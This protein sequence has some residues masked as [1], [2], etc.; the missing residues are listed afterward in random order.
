VEE[1]GPEIDRNIPLRSREGTLTWH[2]LVDGRALMGSAEELQR[3]VSS[4][5]VTIG[6]DSV[7]WLGVPMLRDGRVH[8][9]LVV[10]S[11]NEGIGFTHED[12]AVLEFV[13][14]HILTALEANGHGTL[15][16]IDLDESG[17][18]I[19][20]HLKHRLWQFK[21]DGATFLSTERPHADIV[22]EDGLHDPLGTTAILHAVR[23]HVKP[24]LLLSHDA[25]HYIVGRDVRQ[26]FIDVYGKCDTVLIEPADCGFAW[27][28]E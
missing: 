16:S 5:L 26:A 15:S 25:E 7:D 14:S 17:Q 13:G 3:Q 1:A 2:V 6:P 27:R 21:A 20:P 4:P 9:A 23:D 22:F 19:P 24:R 10:Q 11:Y 18:L 8:G 12:R 28:V